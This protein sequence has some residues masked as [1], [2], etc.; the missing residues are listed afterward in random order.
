MLAGLA[1]HKPLG[2]FPVPLQHQLGPL[3]IR[4]NR[5]RRSISPNHRLYYLSPSNPHHET[6]SHYRYLPIYLPTAILLPCYPATILTQGKPKNTK[7]K[8]EELAP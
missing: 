1:S 4:V 7:E 2:D 6:Q 3:P 8:K 5:H